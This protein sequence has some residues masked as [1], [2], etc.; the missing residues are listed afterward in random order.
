MRKN[1]SAVSSDISKGEH[2]F[3]PPSDASR[4]LGATQDSSKKSQI[5][6]GY[7]ILVVEDSPDNQILFRRMLKVAGAEVDVA[8]NGQRG[9]EH[10][11]QRVYDVIVMDIRMPVMDGYEATFRIRELGYRGPIVALTAHA[12][13]GEE[14]RC[15]S[16]GCT[17][18][19]TKPVDR[20]GLIETLRSA[21][22]FGRRVLPG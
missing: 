14:E 17:H 16:V 6:E 11:A 4:C 1:K 15:R 3:F 8:E 7:S 19:L 9:V 13:P 2:E 21:C 22:L 20:E 12:I 18:F 5:L 10:L